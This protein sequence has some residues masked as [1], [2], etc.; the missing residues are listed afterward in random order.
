MVLDHAQWFQAVWSLGAPRTPAKLVL[1]D[2][3]SPHIPWSMKPPKWPKI[4]QN[5]ELAIEWL[6]T[7]TAS[8][9]ILGQFLKDYGDKTSPLKTIRICK[10]KTD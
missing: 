1:G 6:G 8:N 7:K 5:Q 3:N 4:Q 2:S 10:I 9:E